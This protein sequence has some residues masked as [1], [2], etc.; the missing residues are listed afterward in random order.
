MMRF[1]EAQPHLG[2][3][4]TVLEIY[5]HIQRLVADL[6]IIEEWSIGLGGGLRSR[7]AILI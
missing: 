1:S 4:R 6:H 3:I 2:T 5:Q 7:S